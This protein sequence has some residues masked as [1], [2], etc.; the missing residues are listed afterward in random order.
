MLSA[1]NPPNP[2][3]TPPLVN[4]VAVYRHLIRMKRALDEEPHREGTAMPEAGEPVPSQS[5]G[6]GDDV[7]S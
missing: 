6:G 7:S 4:M 1:G 2:S 5:Q 3:D